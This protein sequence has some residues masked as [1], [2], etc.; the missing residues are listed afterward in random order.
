MNQRIPVS[1]FFKIY[2]Y[3]QITYLEKLLNFSLQVT[4]TVKVQNIGL[5]NQRL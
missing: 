4:D 3:F 1:T 2:P 5:E